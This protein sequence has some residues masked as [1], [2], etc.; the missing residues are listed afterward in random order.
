MFWFRALMNSASRLISAGVMVQLFIGALIKSMSL[1]NVL[2]RAKYGSVEISI[3]YRSAE[4]DGV[5]V[6]V[7]GDVVRGTSVVGS[8]QLGLVT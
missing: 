2:F 3:L 6:K 7:T 5:H 1:Q 4:V 8:T